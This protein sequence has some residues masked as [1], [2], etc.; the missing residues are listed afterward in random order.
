M[1]QLVLNQLDF[2][3]VGEIINLKDAAALQSP[4]TLAQLNKAI[5]GLSPKDNCRVSTQ[6]N[7]NLTSPGATIDGITMSSGDRV[8]IKSQT[9]A[10]ENGI[11]IWNGSAIAMTRS[12]DTNTGDKLESAITVV[13]EGTSQGTAC[14]QSAVNFTIGSGTVQWVQFGVVAVQATEIV[15][16]IAYVATQAIVDAGTDDQRFITPLKLKNSPFSRKGLSMVIGDGTATQY[17][18]THNFG[19]RD[20]EINVYQNSSPWDKY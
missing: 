9:A 12:T 6:A 14:R 4:V 13:D 18:I 8:L 5:E 16:G 19:T 15:S 3:N 2:S 17:D 7:I 11:Y 20:I 1:S 10:S